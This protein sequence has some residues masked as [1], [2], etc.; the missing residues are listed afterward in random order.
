MQKT[1][2]FTITRKQNYEDV[3]ELPEN[4]FNGIVLPDKSSLVNNSSLD[5]EANDYWGIRFV[6]E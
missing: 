4:V 2:S 1:Y 5:A 6:N 3:T